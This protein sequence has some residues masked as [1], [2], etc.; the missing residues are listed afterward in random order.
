MELKIPVILDRITYIDSVWIL[1]RNDDHFNNKD[2]AE[3]EQSCR[4]VRS[5]IID[6]RQNRLGNKYGQ[7][8]KLQ[9]PSDEAF[10][11]LDKRY[12][13]NGDDRILITR[14][15]CALDYIVHNIIDAEEL[16][17]FFEAH[18]IQLWHRESVVNHYKGTIYYR[19]N[20]SRNNIALY[21]DKPSKITG[22][23]CHHLEYKTI[24]ADAL[25]CINIFNITDLVDFDHY[26]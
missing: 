8:V 14:V 16:Q 1:I 2:K 26:E 20:G 10:L 22:Q 3:L 18:L 12:C 17:G 7:R 11:W 23:P 6:A 19:E 4:S 21:P 9:L 24:G 25:R 15:D 5:E 13:S